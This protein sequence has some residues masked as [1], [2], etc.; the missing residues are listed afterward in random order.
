MPAQTSAQTTVQQT[1]DPQ[2]FAQQP[3]AQQPSAQQPSTQ[4]P[5]TVHTVRRPRL[6]KLVSQSLRILESV[7]PAI[8]G[9]IA[10]QMF[11]TPLRNYFPV[12][13]KEEAVLEQ[14]EAKLLRYGRYRRHYLQTFTWTPENESDQTPTILLLHGWMASASHLSAFV[15]P[16]LD[17]GYRV[18]A[19]D[20][21]AHG[22]SSGFQ[23]SMPEFGEAICQLVAELGPIDSIIAHSFGAA[24]SLFLLH[25]QPNAIAI[26]SLVTLAS[27][28][29]VTKMMQ[30]VVRGLGG[31]DRLR[32]EMEKC[33]LKRYGNPVDH[34]AIENMVVDNPLPGLVIHDRNDGLIDFSEG[35][36]IAQSWPGAEFIATDGLGHGGILRDPDVIEQ[37]LQF[38]RIHCPVLAV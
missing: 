24:S 15:G 32:Q 6:E 7:S 31:S 14:G 26:N 37:V 21:P 1:S 19:M 20:A 22:R 13:P 3:S 36:A 34:Y 25:Y 4:Q 16:L 9:R 38:Q 12:C 11:L 5:C 18:I 8:A 27:P 2:L 17:A 33:F 28:S 29:Q 30:I 10:F 23:T 35:E